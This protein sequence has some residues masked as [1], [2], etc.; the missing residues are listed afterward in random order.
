MS[1]SKPRARN[2]KPANSPLIEP[3]TTIARPLLAVP[4]ILR[5]PGIPLSGISAILFQQPPEERHGSDHAEQKGGAVR[6]FGMAA[7]D[8][9]GI[10]TRKPRAQ[11]LRRHATAIRNGQGSGLDHP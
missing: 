8:Q 7:G 2:S 3:P 4:T 10:R 1:T 6:P 11:W 9:D 5:P